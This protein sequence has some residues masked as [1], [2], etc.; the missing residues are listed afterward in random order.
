MKLC[1]D[2]KHKLRYGRCGHPLN[3][4]VDLV[5]GGLEVGAS[6]YIMCGTLRGDYVASEVFWC[7]PE[8]IHFEQKPTQSEDKPW[9]KFW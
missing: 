3:M 8:A 7:G 1:I 4:K 6:G 5:D 2:C 9:W